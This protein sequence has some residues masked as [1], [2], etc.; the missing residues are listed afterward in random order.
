MKNYLLVFFLF[1]LA[2]LNR[3]RNNA[4]CYPGI[5]CDGT[6][7]D[8]YDCKYD[9]KLAANNASDLFAIITRC[10]GKIVVLIFFKNV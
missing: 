5:L 7:T 10:I 2:I 8:F 1:Y 6:E 3:I 9:R 4:T